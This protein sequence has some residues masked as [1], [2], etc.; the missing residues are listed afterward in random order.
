MSMGEVARRAR[1]GIGTVYR[2]FPNKRALIG[3]VLSEQLAELREETERIAG[4]AASD[5]ALF[6]VLRFLVKTLSSV[7]AWWPLQN[8]EDQVGG[9]PRHLADSVGPI[10]QNLLAEAQDL[11]RVR[12]NLDVD[13]VLALVVGIS[14]VGGR[15][16]K[17]MPERL[18]SI[19]I[20]GLRCDP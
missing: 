9:L 10:L 19:V 2:Q 18:V 20:E 15:D 12:A 8:R 13:E 1:V 14:A 11:R 17:P 16:P 7:S 5:E 3:F 6:S 4:S